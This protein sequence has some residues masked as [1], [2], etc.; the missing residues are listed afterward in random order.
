MSHYIYRLFINF[1]LI[2]Y[3]IYRLVRW[4][5]PQYLHPPDYIPFAGR[6]VRPSATL[7]EIVLL[8]QN[9]VYKSHAYLQISHINLFIFLIFNLFFQIPF[10]FFN[11]FNWFSCV[12]FCLE[13]RIA[14]Y[15][16]FLLVFSQYHCLM[17]LY[18]I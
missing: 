7:N 5:D 9:F 14:L 6:T 17:Y 11:N 3:F 10:S 4:S 18:L 15:G 8:S 13:K 1:L 2:H 16:N 12:M